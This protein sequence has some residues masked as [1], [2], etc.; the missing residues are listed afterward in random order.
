MIGAKDMQKFKIVVFFGLI[1]I[2]LTAGRS[3]ALSN[4]ELIDF[5][6]TQNEAAKAKI[7]SVSY[8]IEWESEVDTKKGHRINKASGEVKMK[9]DN[10]WS[11]F[12]AHASIPES[13]WQQD[14]T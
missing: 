8:K 2:V 6:I 4:E 12:K 13:G 11:S 1:S 3:L 9:G 14:Q 5:L 10:R 7:A